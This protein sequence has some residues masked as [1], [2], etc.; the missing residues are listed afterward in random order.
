[1]PPPSAFSRIRTQD[2]TQIEYFTD[3][4]WLENGLSQNSLS[5]YRT[6]LALFSLWLKETD[7]DCLLEQATELHL[8]G[9]L[10]HFSQHAK[11]T[12]QRRLLASFRRYF[13]WRVQHH[14]IA[15]DPS[16]RIAQ[17][18]KT[19][20]LPKTLSESQVEGLI[21]APDTST[22][23]GLRDRAMI[24]LMYASGLRVS[25]LI[26][27]KVFELSFDE[28]YIRV[29]GKGDKQ[30]LVPYGL[31]A[32]HWL[33]RYNKEARPLL[34]KG[35]NSD[36]FFISARQ[37]AMTRQMFWHIIKRYAQ[38]AQIPTKQISPHTLRHAFATH[39][40]NHGADLRVVQL[41]LGHA[42]ITTTQI[43]THVARERL[44]DIHTQHHP[45]SK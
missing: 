30:R 6:D 5:A 10:A 20:R 7:P 28:G 24:E 4:L 43:Y 45:R 18:I 34:L 23:L 41:L 3:S 37:A 11:P 16:A 36:T 44:K 19:E 33:V 40:L 15:V 1:M 31:T 29:T 8:S 39:L 21:Q 25:E 9:Y 22:P 32:E 13:Q 35:K 27:L 2:Q 42:D 26:S 38:L 17:P 12:S 14:N